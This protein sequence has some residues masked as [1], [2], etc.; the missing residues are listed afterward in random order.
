MSDQIDLHIHSNKSSD[1]DFSPFRIVSLAKEKGF[2]AISISDHDTVAAYP[3]ALRIGKKFGVEV[4]PNVEL[5]TCFDDR[6]FH[7]LLPF[8]DWNKRVV[9][10]LVA[11]ISERRKKEARKRVM[12]LQKL[13]LDICWSEVV[14]K[15][16]SFPPLGVTIAQIFLDKA[17]KAGDPGFRRYLDPE[18]RIYA[19]YLFYKDY[20]MEGMPA[21]VPSRNFA[22]LDVLKIAPQT[23]GVPVLAHPGAYFQHTS[24]E[25]LV[26]LKEKGLEGLEIYTSY[27]DAD[28]TEYYKI[29]AGELDLVPTSGSDFHG[30]IKPNVPFGSVKNG[31]Y[32]MVE[33]LKKRRA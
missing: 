27:H 6:E 8:I 24:R 23:G 16:G 3:K 15:C 2:R 20:F 13:G 25:D 11:E 28:Q 17:E 10:D 18:N 30:T 31:G 21:F 14:N 26:L 22:L 29:L 32:W 7:L 33:E 1:G 9:T 12:K 4:I 19:P 5:T